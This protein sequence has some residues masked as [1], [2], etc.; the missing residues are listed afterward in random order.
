MTVI[1]REM[2]A[3]SEKRTHELLEKQ[4]SHHRLNSLTTELFIR[5]RDYL[6][7]THSAAI[8]TDLNTFMTDYFSHLFVEVYHKSVVPTR[9]G[10]G[11]SHTNQDFDS[12][13][14]GAYQ[15]IGPFGDLPTNIVLNLEQ[16]LD[17]SKALMRSL[18]LAEHVLREASSAANLRPSPQCVRHVGKMTSCR[19]C[20]GHAEA[21][22]C[23]GYCLNVMRGCTVDLAVLDKPW[24]SFVQSLQRLSAS[25]IGSRNAENVLPEL[26]QR[27]DEAI[28]HALSNTHEIARRVSFL[29]LLR[30]LRLYARAAAKMPPVILMNVS[31]TSMCKL[32]VIQCEREKMRRTFHRKVTRGHA[33]CLCERV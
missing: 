27:L 22:V 33:L 5:I 4:Y 25:W 31:A 26:D 3:S 20:A 19:S 7:D 8:R 10:R 12:C 32:A 21:A 18:N 14:H 23:A 28:K 2:I 16:S 13:L 29:R 6:N 15:D 1:F 17:S 30:F 9:G 11:G 24:S